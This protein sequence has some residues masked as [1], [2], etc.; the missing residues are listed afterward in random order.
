MRIRREG[1]QVGEGAVRILVI[2]LLGLL[3]SVVMAE[4]PLGMPEYTQTLEVTYATPD[5]AQKA[6]LT[7]QELPGTKKVALSARW[8]DTNNRHLK[9]AQTMARQN[10]KGTFYLCNFGSPHQDRT[11]PAEILKL[12]SSL[13]SHTVNH[14]YLCQYLPASVFKQIIDQRVWEESNYNTCVTGF[15]LP[16]GNHTTP[17]KD[18]VPAMIGD[19]LKRSG[20]LGGPAWFDAARRF[21]LSTDIW[22]GSNRF[23]CNDKDPSPELFKK[24]IERSLVQALKPDSPCG[25]HITLGTHTWQ[26]DQ[27]FEVLEG[28]FKEYANNPDWWYCNEN[29]YLAYRYQFLHCGIQK[30]SVKGKTVVYEITRIAAPELGDDIAL[31]VRTEGAVAVAKLDGKN[32][33]VEDGRINLPQSVGRTVPVEI[34]A[35][36]L[37]GNSP[38]PVQSGNFNDIQMKFDEKSSRVSFSL[39]V[40]SSEKLEQVSV[41]L[42]VP[43]AWKDG[44]KRATPKVVNSGIEASFELG[45]RDLRPGFQEG[46]YNFYVQVDALCNGTPKRLHAVLTVPNKLPADT[47]GP[48]NNAWAVGPFTGGTLTPELLA[49]LSMPS[50]KLKDLGTGEFEKWQP[51]SPNPNVASPRIGINTSTKARAFVKQAKTAECAFVLEFEAKAGEPCKL[52]LSSRGA[53]DV[54]AIYV[55]GKGYEFN[56]SIAL[57]PQAGRN[58]VVL[59]YKLDAAMYLANQLVSVTTGDDL[60]THV[61][62]LP[63]EGATK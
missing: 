54:P 43:P 8:D 30:K 23:S 61:K 17:F 12:G 20:H 7:K 58:R 51:V 48:R 46:D 29:E 21:E 42:R 50:A 53:K 18:Y 27:G 36:N 35:V 28:L 16:Y 41:V 25:P 31:T 11:V 13:G 26:S 49:E 6:E 10:W 39:K 34:E 56:R 60:F 40:G 47:T 14:P 15:V 2:G 22:F 52:L 4:N 45:E 44:V 1:I 5:E 9:M 38:A 57:S 55:N 62:F 3:G 33:T 63:V 19:A 32:L 59:V 37:K 24:G